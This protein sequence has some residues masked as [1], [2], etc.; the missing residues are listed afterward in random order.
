MAVQGTPAMA[1]QGTPALVATSLGTM[2]IFV[3]N[4]EPN[5]SAAQCQ[6]RR[7]VMLYILFASVATP[8]CLMHSFV[9]SVEPNG[10][11][12]RNRQNRQTEK[13]VLALNLW[14]HWRTRLPVMKACIKKMDRS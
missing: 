6:R 4:V 3:A 1:V 12:N 5:D 2:R 7:Q 8:F 10:Q 14:T 13:V 9:A 11:R